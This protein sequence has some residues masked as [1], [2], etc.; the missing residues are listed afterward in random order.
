MQPCHKGLKGPPERILHSQSHLVLSCLIL[1][2]L[3]FVRLSACWPLAIATGMSASAMRLQSIAQPAM[4]WHGRMPVIDRCHS[5]LLM[6]EVRGMPL[7]GLPDA[8]AF[9][10]QAVTCKAARCCSWG[11][12]CRSCPA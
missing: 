4:A 11:S 8:F 10:Q 7:F 9:Q 6:Q 2:Y 5:G 1:S 3:A 12:C